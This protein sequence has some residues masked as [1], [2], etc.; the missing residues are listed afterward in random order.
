MLHLHSFLKCQL[1]L[2]EEMVLRSRMGSG[3]IIPLKTNVC[4]AKMRCRC[5]ASCFVRVYLY[6]SV[7]VIGWCS[8]SYVNV[9][10]A[11]IGSRLDSVHSHVCSGARSHANHGFLW[12]IKEIATTVQ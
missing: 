11:V 5:L 9:T 10:V 6:V 7:T 12:H 8:V 1:D 3:V 4:N 2:V